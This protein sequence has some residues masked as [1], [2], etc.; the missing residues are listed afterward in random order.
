MDADIDRVCLWEDDFELLCFRFE[1]DENH[2]S[3]LIFYSATKIESIT[4]VFIDF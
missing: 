2:H 4:F 3:P 1:S